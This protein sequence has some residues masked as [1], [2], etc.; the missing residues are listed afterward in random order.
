MTPH[1]FFFLFYILERTNEMIHFCSQ[2]LRSSMFV[3]CLL[4]VFEISVFTSIS[5][6]RFSNLE[7]YQQEVNEEEV[8]APDSGDKR[9]LQDV[10]VLGHFGP[11]G[12]SGCLSGSYRRTSILCVCVFF[13]CDARRSVCCFLFR[14]FWLKYFGLR[15][16]L[17][18]LTTRRHTD[19]CSKQKYSAPD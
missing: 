15:C 13:S 19:S 7:R 12:S 11:D 3:S 17:S 2:S 18:P 6:Q 16:S 1:S 10:Q 8:D 14:Q 5:G 9:I 4:S